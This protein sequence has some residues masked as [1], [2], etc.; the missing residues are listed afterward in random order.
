MPFC[1]VTVMV[2]LTDGA[3]EPVAEVIALAAAPIR[4]A[5]PPPIAA[6]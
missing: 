6:V 5:T 3:P 1:S 2:V 4:L